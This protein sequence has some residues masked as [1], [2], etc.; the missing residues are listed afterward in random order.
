[1]PLP[2]KSSR[3]YASV[4]AAQ[5]NPWDYLPGAKG[6]AKPVAPL[7]AWELPPLPPSTTSEGEPDGPLPE[8]AR[9]PTC[10]YRF[11]C[12]RCVREESAAWWA[13][14]PSREEEEPWCGEWHEPMCKQVLDEGSRKP[15]PSSP[16]AGM[17]TGTGTGTL[18]IRPSADV[19][20]H[21]APYAR[22]PTPHPSAAS[23][24][25][26]APAHCA[27]CDGA[28][29]LPLQQPTSRCTHGQQRVCAECLRTYLAYQVDNREIRCPVPSCGEV[30]D[31]GEMRRGAAREA[32]DR[33]DTFL[34]R[35]H[36]SSDPAF[37]WC[38]NPACTSGQI[39]LPPSAASSAPSSPSTP[40]L[41]TS[42]PPTSSSSSSSTTPSPLS[43]RPSPAAQEC[44]RTTCH[45]CQT[46]WCTL[47]DVPHPG[48]TCAQYE[49]R[50]SGPLGLGLGGEMGKERWRERRVRWWIG[51]RTRSCPGCGTHIERSEGC[52]HIT[53]YPPAGCGYHFCW[54]C[55]A[56][57]TLIFRIGNHGH[58]RWCKH[59]RPE[60]AFRWDFWRG[61]RERFGVVEVW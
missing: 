54:R 34:L 20:Q 5:G 46:T 61:R 26:A 31:V 25:P 16:S 15:A 21:H 38:K 14:T 48:L 24:P 13:V 32:F 57:Y 58:R 1:M 53:C 18:L 45:A 11:T 10:G 49:R 43:P 44:T 39:L 42:S 51:R 52:D 17:E 23:R 6:R 19:D 41:S 56:D 47:H 37:S 27:I 28:L 36:L 55:G 8:P 29:P 9:C 7:R 4:L 40:T 35:R 3:Y 22:P 60:K 30:L 59:F 33:W 50:R 2:T 12:A